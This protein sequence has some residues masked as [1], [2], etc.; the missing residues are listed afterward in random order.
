MSS[1]TNNEEHRLLG[2]SQRNNASIVQS[3]NEIVAA[4]IFFGDLEQCGFG[5]S[6][7]KADMHA[8]SIRIG[9]MERILILN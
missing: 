6:G 7:D 2:S 3:K 1:T 9:E 8:S 5:I 4:G